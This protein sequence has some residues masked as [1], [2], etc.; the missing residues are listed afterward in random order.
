MS[1]SQLRAVFFDLDGTLADTA[2]DLGGA[3][4][5]LLQEEGRSPLPM[6]QLRPYVSGGARALLRTGFGI[7]P[8]D[9]GYPDLQRR[10]LDLYARHICVDTRL[11]DGMDDVLATLENK[12]IL[13]GI[14]TNKVERFTRDV[15]AGLG[16]AERAASVISGD[17]APRPKPAP[18]PLLMAADLAGLA[19]ETC[20]YVGD[21]LRD[22]Q[23][24]KAAGMGTVTAAWGYLG[25]SPDLD[26]WQAD[27]ICRHPQDLLSLI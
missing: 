27:H 25:E 17:S 20:L 12:G 7:T 24:G 3:L 9:T 5:R 6:D 13:W 10:F 22:I 23:A 1:A 21:D 8:D 19:P 4:N 14:I 15:V 18:D 2:P 16:L 26:A 11:F